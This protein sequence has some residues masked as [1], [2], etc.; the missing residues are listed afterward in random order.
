[1]AEVKA[2][3]LPDSA[4]QTGQAGSEKVGQTENVGPT[5]SSSENV[6]LAGQS[7]SENA[8][9]P[10]GESSSAKVGLAGRA[11]CDGIEEAGRSRPDD[12]L[13]AGPVVPPPAAD[14]APVSLA[15]VSGGLVPSGG[16]RAT[17]T[18]GQQ[19][20]GVAM[21]TSLVHRKIN[22]VHKLER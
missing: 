16:H 11:N 22:H 9:G 14:V 5:G 8:G 3:Q 1:M 15:R 19:L 13:R 20:G 2:E 18:A 17:L 4:G 7:I 21:A 12:G 6:G 10:T